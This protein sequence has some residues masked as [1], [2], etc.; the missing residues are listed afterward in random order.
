MSL[1]VLI[2]LSIMMGL[3]GL[4]AFTWALHNGQ[5]EDPKGNAERVLTADVAARAKGGD[6][7]IAAGDEGGRV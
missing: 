1:L 2:P 7:A 4:G 3:I 6:D 5:F